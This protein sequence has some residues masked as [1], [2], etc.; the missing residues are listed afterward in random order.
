MVD[1]IEVRGAATLAEVVAFL[2]G[3]S[4][5]PICR[6]N[7]DA[8][9]AE[10]AGDSVDFA[11]VRG[12]GAAKRAFEVAAAGAHNVLLIGPPGAGKTMLARRLS[13]ILPAAHA[14]RSSRN[15]GGALGRGVAVA[16]QGSADRAA[17]S[18]AASHDQRCGSHRGRLAAQARR[19]E[20]RA[21]R[22]ALPRRAT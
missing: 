8:L 18:R 21:G 10:R 5:L 1:G 14:R 12:Q 4:D 7:P 16:G 13:T 17:L 6:G 22:G 15:H 3:Q 11:D 20:P 2:R 9:L 19:G